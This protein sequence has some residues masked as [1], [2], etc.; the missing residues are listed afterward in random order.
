[1]DSNP[2]LP[3]LLLLGREKI[4]QMSYSDHLVVK[5]WHAMPCQKYAQTF[6][7]TPWNLE[8]LCKFNFFLAGLDWN[9]VYSAL[10]YGPESSFNQFSKTDN[11]D[12][13]NICGY[14]LRSLRINTEKQMP[15]LW[16]NT[17]SSESESIPRYSICHG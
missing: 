6:G 7:G 17:V 2:H 4:T 11:E 8:D 14:I 10:C 16:D 12:T 15:I 1:M 5:D 9:Q 3:M 13:A